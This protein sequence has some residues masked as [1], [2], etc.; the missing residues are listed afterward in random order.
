MI[1]IQC[2]SQITRSVGNK[3]NNNFKDLYPKME[4]YAQFFLSPDQSS[5]LENEISEAALTAIEN[6]IR[7]CSNE[8]RERSQNIIKL[9]K[10][11][12]VYDP[13]YQYNQDMDGEDEEMND[14]NEGWG[15][16]YY[17]EQQDDD[18]DTAWKVRKSSIK[19]FDAFI[20]SC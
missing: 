20:T 2:I 7:K 6:L 5:D 16:D 17:D 4:N 9:A 13:N 10:F 1:L 19:V 11:C 18:D 12:L 14:E 3:L 15:S 8:A